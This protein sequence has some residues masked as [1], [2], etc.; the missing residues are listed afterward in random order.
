MFH[1]GPRTG[2]LLTSLLCVA[3]DLTVLSGIVGVVAY[4]IAPRIMTRIEGE[5]LLVEDLESRRK[6]LRN[7]V[8]TILAKSDGWLKEEIR[9]RVYPRFLSWGFL[10]RQISKREELKALLAQARQEFKQRT[11]RLTTDEERD[12]LIAAVET[13]VTLRRVDALLALHWLLRF[14]IPMHIAATAIML[15][16]MLVHIIQV[17]FFNVR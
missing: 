1:S 11:T 13:A 7:D 6:E 16:L 17:V 5:P 4:V 10:W 12:L 9:D 8:R 2:G 15:G 14:W 3:F